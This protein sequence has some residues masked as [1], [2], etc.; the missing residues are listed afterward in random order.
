MRPIPRTALLLAGAT[1]ALSSTLALAAPES[2]LPP[3]FG[4]PAPA[5]TPTP[6][7]SQ[8]RPAPSTPATPPPA[9]TVSVPVIQQLPGA[10]VPAAPVELPRDVLA[11]LP[12]LKE[13]EAMDADEIDELLGLKP[14]FDIP[15]GARRSLEQVGILGAGEG[16]FAPQALVA[17]PP[18]LVRA[19]LAGTKGPLVSRWGH[20]LLRRALASRLD[21]PA[22][23]DPAEFAALRAALLN[24]IGEGAVARQL[25]QDVDTDRY[26]TALASAAFDAYLA[27]GDLIGICPVIRLKPTL[28]EDVQWEMTRSICA[29]Y[30]GDGRRAG[31]ELNR[32]LS[33]GSAP[34]IDVLLAQ[35]YAGAA[36]D[37][38]RAVNIEWD[39]VQ[40]L[41][42]WTFSLAR[43]LGV[44]IPSGLRGDPG[45]V[46]DYSE[47]LIPAAPLAARVSAADAA[48]ERGV[49]S[50][51]GYV[52][53]L[54][55]AYTDG[56][57]DGPLRE[58][59]QQLRA[60]YVARDLTARVAAMRSL[61]GDTRDW[62]GLVLTARAAAR[63]PVN[64][65]L[66]DDAES[67]VASMLSAGLDR[68]ALRW[69]SLV[70]EGSGAWAQLALAQPNRTAPI[71]GN[72]F[73]TFMGED[74]SDGQRRSQFLLAGLAGLGRLPQGEVTQYA[75]ELRVDF[76]RETAWS[77]RID[78]AGELGN[79][80][81]VALLAAV[82]MQGDGWDRMTARHL[83]HIVRAL[84][85]AGLEAEARMIA[86]EAVARG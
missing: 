7:Q 68:N 61:W 21:A 2:L 1:L 18:E 27:T 12:T 33:R 44:E 48:A 85:G 71:S 38:R 14:Q 82:G 53:L 57:S 55:L 36:G 79:P 39:G 10:S 23:M 22:G 47:V 59:A 45:G 80:A 50:A 75:R 81:L 43:A 54:S 46:L 28:R 24:R 67:I 56:A 86:A 41:D 60:A 65:L 35:R 30:G 4:Q 40:K 51:Q 26:D 66:L 70:P 13:L 19:A 9:G 20:I 15:P 8:N 62:G 11:K 76:T 74:S 49:L 31:Q 63:L 5:P 52:D 72:G 17:Q 42:P 83:F 3:S 25:V 6:T 64:E 77:R 58:R 78:R 73:E 29:A 37:G 34:R 84:Q 32:T 69:G 16:G